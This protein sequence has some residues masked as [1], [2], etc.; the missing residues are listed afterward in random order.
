MNIAPPSHGDASRPPPS[1]FLCGSQLFVID[2][3]DI[4][5]SRVNCARCRAY[6]G[7]VDDLLSELTLRNRVPWG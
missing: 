2:P 5:E 6:L 3:A 7:R 4:D 1:C